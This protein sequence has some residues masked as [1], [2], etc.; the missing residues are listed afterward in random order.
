MSGFI[1]LDVDYIR[2]ENM[3]YERVKDLDDIN[4]LLE[5]DELWSKIDDEPILKYSAEM[6][7]PLFE[8]YKK[9]PEPFKRWVCELAKV[10]LNFMN[11]DDIWK[12]HRLKILIKA[13]WKINREGDYVVQNNEDAIRVYLKGDLCAVYRFSE[14][15]EKEALTEA[16]KYIH[17]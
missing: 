6:I 7:N 14:M 17:K 8:Y 15:T 1:G 13:M 9:K 16:L 4:I 5:K 11:L 10:D 2:G 12:T 3:E